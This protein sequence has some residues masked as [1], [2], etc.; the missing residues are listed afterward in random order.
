MDRLTAALAVRP[1]VTAG[2]LKIAADT[3]EVPVG[4]RGKRSRWVGMG[5]LGSKTPLVSALSRL[6]SM[7]ESSPW[8][9]AILMP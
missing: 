5:R 8:K 2:L 6:Q 7:A 9:T 3:A 4:Q 1:A